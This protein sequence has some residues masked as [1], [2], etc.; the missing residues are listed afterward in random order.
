MTVWRRAC[1]APPYPCGFQ[2][3]MLASSPLLGSWYPLENAEMDACGL[4]GLWYRHLL[5]F[6]IFCSCFASEP[7]D[8]AHET[9]YKKKK[10]CAR[11]K[12]QS[13]FSTRVLDAAQQV[14]DAGQ[15]GSQCACSEGGTGDLCSTYEGTL[16]TVAPP[17]QWTMWDIA[18]LWLMAAQLLLLQTLP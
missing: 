11:W 5:F 14:L 10:H 4:S 12:R 17:F 3:R 9:E 1:W 18:E 8:V 6:A 15:Q 16:L 7:A 2:F 13:C